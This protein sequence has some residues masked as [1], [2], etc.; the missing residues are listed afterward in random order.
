M[1]T[2]SQ[3]LLERIKSM[4]FDIPEGVV[5]ARTGHGRVQLSRGAWAWRLDNPTANRLFTIGRSCVGSQETVTSLVGEARLMAEYDSFSGDIIV[6]PWAEPDITRP[7][8]R[9]DEPT[10][11]TP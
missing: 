4:G 2:P 6:S 8:R 9:W 11:E 5:V 1:A 7:S 3:R 10:E